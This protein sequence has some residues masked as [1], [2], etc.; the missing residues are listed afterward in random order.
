MI[1]K[2]APIA[3]LSRPGDFG[4]YTDFQ[5]VA[6][7]E[8]VSTWDPSLV[9][10]LTENEDVRKFIDFTA[11]RIPRTLMPGATYTY[12]YYS[13]STV[14]PP[15]SDLNTM[16][17]GQGGDFPFIGTQGEVK[18]STMKNYGVS[19]V[20]EK[21]LAGVD[22]NYERRAVQAAYSVLETS[23]A[24]TVADALDS[25]STTVSVSPTSVTT[26]GETMILP[27]TL[28]AVVSSAN[29]QG[30]F[31]NRLLI[32]PRFWST[33]KAYIWGEKAYGLLLS[34]FSSPEAY[35][36]DA[37][38]E[39][40]LVRARSYSSSAYNT[41]VT[42]K[43]MYIFTGSNVGAELGNTNLAT[44]TN[45]EGIKVTTYDHPQGQLRIHTVS[46]WFDVAVLNSAG[47]YKIEFTT[48]YS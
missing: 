20:T 39:A 41:L 36:A 12:R 47:V 10:G 43:V 40:M 14:I 45:G 1:L 24:A 46:T 17:R 3:D 5:N 19:V 25:I 31:P 34:T 4:F 27:S 37:G 8:P 29:S 11:P 2:D 28:S 32:S 16:V 18:S 15:A 26:A 48:S 38:L 30:S 6:Y 33:L 13:P 44:F 22:P 42:G 23:I 7:A 21:A 35:G 9:A